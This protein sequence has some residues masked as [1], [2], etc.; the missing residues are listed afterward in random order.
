M[1]PLVS[2][3]DNRPQLEQAGIKFVPMQTG[4]RMVKSATV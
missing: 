1:S 2:I 3:I 4:L